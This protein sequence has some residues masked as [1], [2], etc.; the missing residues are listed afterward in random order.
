MK[1]GILAAGFLLAAVS[2]GSF[3]CPRMAQEVHASVQIRTGIKSWQT[4]K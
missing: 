2:L 3:S 1:K 4:G